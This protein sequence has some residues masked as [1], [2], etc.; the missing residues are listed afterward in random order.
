MTATVVQTTAITEVAAASTLVSGALTTSPGNGLMLL[1]GNRTP[2]GTVISV[3]DSAG[4]TWAKAFGIHS[5]STSSLEVWTTTNAS[6]AALSAGTITITVSVGTNLVA[7]RFWE[8]SGAINISIVDQFSVGASAGASAAAASGSTAAQSASGELCFGAIIND[9]AASLRTYAGATFTSATPST[10]WPTVTTG[11]ASASGAQL[12]E[13]TSGDLVIPDTSAQAFSATVS[14][15][16]NWT[17]ACWTVTSGGRNLYTPPQWRN[18]RQ[19]EGSLR[20]SVPTSYCVYRK[21]GVWHSTITPG[22]DELTG[23]DTDP[24]TGLQLVFYTPTII[25]NSLVAEL[26][27]FGPPAV[28]TT[29]AGTITIV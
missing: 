7:A 26:T 29:T 5:T 6:P 25:P 14:T 16:V 27:A 9:G 24:A 15:N 3:T 20:Y 23:F 1:I 13:I 28:G 4:N 10:S 2:S 17:A 22:I 19:I 18:Y 8:L 11:D 12:I 21:G